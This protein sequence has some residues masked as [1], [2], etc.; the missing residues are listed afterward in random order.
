MR[1]Q[2]RSA[3]LPRLLR[4][5][6]LMAEEGKPFPWESLPEQERYIVIDPVILEA[7]RELSWIS[8][9]DRHT[10]EGIRLVLRVAR[11]DPTSGNLVIS[12]QFVR[13][14]PDDSPEQRF[15]PT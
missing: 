15:G 7:I 13:A 5:R 1:A 11:I 8:D 4:G 9:F 2:S 10:L 14:L 6:R 12:A 3:P